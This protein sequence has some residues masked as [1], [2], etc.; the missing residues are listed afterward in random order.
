M[1]I[2]VVNVA[3]KRRCRR[4]RK[5]RDEDNP[6]SPHA[7]GC[8]RPDRRP[9]WSRRPP[10]PI[11]F[12]ISTMT[13]RTRR[14]C[15]RTSRSPA[16]PQAVSTQRSSA[17]GAPLQEGVS[18]SLSTLA[19]GVDVTQYTSGRVFVSLGSP[20]TG[21]SAGNDYAPNFVSPASPNF[22]TRM[23][24]YEI[25]YGVPASGG[26]PTGGA[27]L[28]STDFFGIPLKLQTK[29]GSQPTT[30]TW[31]YNGAVNTAAVFQTLG[32]SAELPDRHGLQHP[33]RP[34]RQRR[35][36]RHDQ[37]AER[38]H[39]PGWFASS[40]QAPRMDG[41]TPYPSFS[42]LRELS[43]ETNGI[44]ATIAGQNGQFS[45]GGPFQNYNLTGVISNSTQTIN[46]M[47]IHSWRS[48]A[49]RHRDER[50]RPHEPS[51]HRRYEG[52]P[53]LIRHLRRESRVQRSAAPVQTPT[54]WSRRR[55]P[56]ISPG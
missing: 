52:E 15:R 17:R 33:R 20:L 49:E 53:D 41:T 10:R 1:F 18:Y 9:S 56:T 25:T 4:T 51:D 13:A 11:W 54:T 30:L 29:G 47:T 48:C 43:P 35:E 23:D 5:G 46:G 36:R 27:N 37:H 16:R 50:E 3:E 22:L 55:S 19:A 39:G 26:P 14:P 40:R 2:V 34:R 45:K 38:T 7:C 44:S 8:A 32:A 12:S 28:S 42:Q 6:L 21:L 31:N 24:K